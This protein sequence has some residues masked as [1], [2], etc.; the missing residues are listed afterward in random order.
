MSSK[1][2]LSTFKMFQNLALALQGS[3]TSD[4]QAGHDLLWGLLLT[5][6]SL[7]W[8]EWLEKLHPSFCLFDIYAAFNVC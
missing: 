5:L 2:V 3:S 6:F 1:F 8:T 7:E 4:W